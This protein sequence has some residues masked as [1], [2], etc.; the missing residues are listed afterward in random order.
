[1]VKFLKNTIICIQI[2]KC[3]S[4]LVLLLLF[5]LNSYSYY[6]YRYFNKPVFK[7]HLPHYWED[8][9]PSSVSLSYFRKHVFSDLF[10]QIFL[11]MI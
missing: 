5:K 2:Y 1:M 10:L 9:S 8:F 6:Y 7:I 3:L 4:P 11:L